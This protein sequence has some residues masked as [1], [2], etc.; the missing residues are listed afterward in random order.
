MKKKTKQN[1][2]LYVW[3]CECYRVGHES[4]VSTEGSPS[5][6]CDAYAGWVI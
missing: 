4:K 2:G 1:S 3:N 5:E 6:G